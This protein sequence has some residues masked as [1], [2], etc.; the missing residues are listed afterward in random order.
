MLSIQGDTARASNT[1]N[2]DHIVACTHVE[3]PDQT[4]RRPGHCCMMSVDRAYQLNALQLARS[5]GYC[6][7]WPM[8]S[9]ELLG[10]VGVRRGTSVFVSFSHPK[11]QR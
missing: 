3:R 8:L 10:F 9:L 6:G 4:T 5:G 7:D 2:K 11:E 1:S